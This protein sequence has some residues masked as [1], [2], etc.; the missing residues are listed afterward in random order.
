M[1]PTT[2]ICQSKAPKVLMQSDMPLGLRRALLS[3]Q[4]RQMSF[5]HITIR[6]QST[7]FA[8]L[9]RLNYQSHGIEIV[10]DLCSSLIVFGNISENKITLTKVVSLELK[11]EVCE[12][13][14]N[15]RF[16]MD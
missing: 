3:V 6:Y 10:S 11:F 12:M 1:L 5:E 16:K 8:P 2:L 13:G 14:E 7:K 4:S 9:C 15:S